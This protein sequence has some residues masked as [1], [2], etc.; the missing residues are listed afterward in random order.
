M[1]RKPGSPFKSPKASS[2][3]P[4]APNPPTPVWMP[5]TSPSHCLSSC[6]KF[7]KNRFHLSY[8]LINSLRVRAS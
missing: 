3:N 8:L 2:V 7:L 6:L 4:H 1:V 5:K